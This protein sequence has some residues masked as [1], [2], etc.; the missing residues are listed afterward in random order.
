MPNDK[1]IDWLVI[2]PHGSSGAVG[3]APSYGVGRLYLARAR[4]RPTTAAVLPSESAGAEQARRAGR[5][6]AVAGCGRSAIG[7]DAGT[8]HE[9]PSRRRGLSRQAIVTKLRSCPVSTAQETRLG[10]SHVLYE[11]SPG[12]PPHRGTCPHVFFEILY[13]ISSKICRGCV[14]PLELR[15]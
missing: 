10:V 3:A 9:R 15:I 7:R 4:T 8:Q 13:R 5:A 2:V 6:R 11:A 12:S 14:P 1:G